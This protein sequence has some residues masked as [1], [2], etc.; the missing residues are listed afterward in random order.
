MR[1][2]ATIRQ[3][4]HHKLQHFISGWHMM[5]ILK[6]PSQALGGCPP[7][8]VVALNCEFFNDWY[9]LAMNFWHVK[10]MNSLLQVFQHQQVF[11]PVAF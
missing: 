8:I 3:L 4:F 6:Y 2:A 1:E 11:S 5:L 9:K 10:E 7:D